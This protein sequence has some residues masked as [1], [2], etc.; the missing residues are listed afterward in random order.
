MVCSSNVRGG[1]TARADMAGDEWKPADLD[2]ISGRLSGS[3]VGRG[4]GAEKGR[5]L[6]V[7]GYS[8]APSRWAPEAALL[9]SA[10]PTK[11]PVILRVCLRQTLTDADKRSASALL[12]QCIKNVSRE[13]GKRRGEV[14]WLADPSDAGFICSVYGFKPTGNRQRGRHILVYYVK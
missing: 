1:R 5:V 9:Y 11:A 12:V 7:L 4:S 13:M 10:P 3:R 14:R 2:A 6:Y 8:I